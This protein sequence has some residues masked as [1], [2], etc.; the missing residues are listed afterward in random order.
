[1]FRY[2]N[3]Q[4]DDSNLSMQNPATPKTM[5][6]YTTDSIKPIKNHDYYFTRSK[7]QKTAAWVLLGGGAGL[8]GAAFLIGSRSSSSFGEAETG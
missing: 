7:N 2:D 1:M 4:A 6:V 3:K 8:I 5:F